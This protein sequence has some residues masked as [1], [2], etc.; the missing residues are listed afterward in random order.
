MYLIPPRLA[1]TKKEGIVY[2]NEADILNLALFGMTAK[3]WQGENPTLKGN[4]RD[5]ATA[6]QLL[7][8]ANLETLNAHFIKEG[9]SQTERLVKLNETAI[10]QMELF[11]D[12]SVL[13]RLQ[14]GGN[15]I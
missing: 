9:L 12:T 8:L 5:H 11:A 14:G 15:S 2:A 4:I 3:Q 7:V 1:N 10:Y 13:K 6:E